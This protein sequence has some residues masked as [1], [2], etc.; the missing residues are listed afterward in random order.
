MGVE[1]ALCTLPFPC[2]STS[3][4]RSGALIHTV[5]SDL[6]PRR[7]RDVKGGGVSGSLVPDGGRRSGSRTRLDLRGVVG[8]WRVQGSSRAVYRGGRR[9]DGSGLRNSVRTRR[10][11][12]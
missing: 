2:L 8:V 12:E 3:I 4:T 10:E 7:P 9:V 5:L 6:V 1:G 11:G